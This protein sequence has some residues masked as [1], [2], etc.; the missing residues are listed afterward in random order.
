M[1]AS[2]G[3]P[4]KSHPYIPA[5]GK[6]GQTKIAITYAGD[7]QPVQELLKLCA[8]RGVD[9][10]QTQQWEIETLAPFEFAME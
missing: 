1:V 3:I 5:V 8:S 2:L 9:Q 4:E 10:E 7:E 6:D